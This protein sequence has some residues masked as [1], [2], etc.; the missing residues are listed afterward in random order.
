MSDEAS[1]QQ[2]GGLP[3][4]GDASGPVW[5]DRSTGL[6]DGSGAP[7][8]GGPEGL[9]AGRGARHT[10]RRWWR[11]WMTLALGM[12]LAMVLGVLAA[13]VP[14]PYAILK[15]GPATDVL[16]SHPGS[17]GK[18]VPRIVVDGASTFPTSG[19]LEF[20][21]VRVT[22]GPGYPVNAWDVLSAWASPSEDVYPVEELFP[23]QATQ[24]Q[25]AQE[26]KAEMAGSQQEAA[27][28]ALRSLG[29][30]VTQVVVVRQVVAGGPSEGELKAGDILV[31]IAATPA[32]DSAAIRSAIQA[33]TPGDAV[34]VVV[35]RAGSRVTTHPRTRKA[36]DGRTVLGI[37]LG[38]DYK[39]PFRVTIDVGNVGGPSAGLMFALGIYDTLTEGSMTGGAT[40]AGTG[41]IDDAGNVGPI[42]G[43]AQK[44][45]GARQGGATA[46]LA[47]AGN[48]SEV[49]GREPAGLQV[50]KVSTFEEARAAVVALASGQASGL[51]R[52]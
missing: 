38:T 4:L 51:P 3:P 6:G 40:I 39:L 36:D 50:V 48:C 9:G 12:G 17:D 7:Y 37:L 42:G 46:F 13:V 27:A 43:I 44:M 52:C 8:S 25:V 29:M 32:A 28:V 26:N 15:P 19:A 18:P 22:G 41:T 31:S 23:P 1:A 11:P 5:G 2:T 49:L 45:V 34:E 35:E 10:R 16:A 14:L 47:P 33:V 21:T 24:E 30:E 20:T